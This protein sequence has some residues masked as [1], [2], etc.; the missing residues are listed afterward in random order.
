MSDDTS[1]AADTA[2]RQRYWRQT[3]TLTLALLLCWGL[4]IFGSL[5]FAR[6]LSAIQFFG[7]QLSFYLAAQ[8]LTFLFVILLALY[9][10]LMRRIGRQLRD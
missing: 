9:S 6:E 5:F 3:R 8:G 2:V 4:A 1:P 7:W 10:L